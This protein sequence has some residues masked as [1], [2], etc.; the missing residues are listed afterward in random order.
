M[1]KKKPRCRI[2]LEGEGFETLF[3]GTSLDKWQGDFEGYTPVNGAIYVMSGDFLLKLYR[4]TGDKRYLE[5]DKDIS[6]NVIQYVNTPFNKVQEHGGPGYCTERV[7]IG[8]WEGSK[9]IGALAD[10]DSNQA[11]ENVALYHMTQNPGIYVETDTGEV[12]V[13]DHVLARLVDGKLEITNP[14]PCDAIVSVLAE[15]T[16]QARGTSLGWLT[17][18]NWPVVSV[19]A[20]QTVQIKL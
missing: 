2:I 17:Y 9:G 15:S 11:W 19:P 7:N 6:H 20:G 1:G 3:D 10:S 16:A 8:D 13:F 12:T 14:T 4:A 18:Y 5:L